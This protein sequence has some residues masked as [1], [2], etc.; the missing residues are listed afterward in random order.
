M[1]ECVLVSG[2]EKIPCLHSL[3]LCVASREQRAAKDSGGAVLVPSSHTCSHGQESLLPIPQRGAGPGRAAS[4]LT[5]LSNEA[6]TQVAKK[7]H[8]K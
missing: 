7:N 3:L 5:V 4:A 6:G 1:Q 8:K 2:R